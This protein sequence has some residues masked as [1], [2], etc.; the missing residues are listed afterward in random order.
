MNPAGPLPWRFRAVVA[1]WFRSLLGIP[2]VAVLAGA[3]LAA[4]TAT[5]PSWVGPLPRVT[6]VDVA[7]RIL[8][9]IG[10]STLSLA[11]FV[12]TIATLALQFGATTY[13]P[14]LVEQLRR[15]RLLRLSLGG[16]LGTFIYAILVMLAV[17]K[18]HPGVATV[19]TTVAMAGATATVLLFIGLLDRLTAML[20]PGRTMARLTHDAR[21]VLART[22]PDPAT[23]DPDL[24]P[25]M[26]PEQA[27]VDWAGLPAAGVVWRESGHGHL[28]DVDVD[29]LV[30]IAQEHDL[31]IALTLPIGAFLPSREAIAILTRLSTGEPV[32][33]DEPVA[34]AIRG[35][36]QVGDERTVDAD[37]AFPIRLL[38]DIA[39]RA[40]SPGVNDPTTAS[41]AI[42]HL[43]QVL[44]DAAGRRLGAR[45]VVRDGR[46]LVTRPA[47]GWDGLLD[48]AWTE[49]SAFG[50]DPQSAAALRRALGRLA[51]RVGPRRSAVQRVM[52][53]VAQNGA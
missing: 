34:E 1:R 12:L 27:T 36:L 39:V 37:P 32:D 44:G 52:N 31:H 24:V 23:E 17:N 19:A 41:Q 29:A 30:R 25:T 26:M 7:Q 21:T 11:G 5:L 3:S 48:L 46:T 35:T 15:E 28:L 40:L 4:L 43:G 47:P 2:V 53:E 33:P 22:Y 13:A 38:V 20:R 14:R 51:A 49:I 45:A 6:T 8:P 18:E 9:A 10:G 42:D 50:T 16:A